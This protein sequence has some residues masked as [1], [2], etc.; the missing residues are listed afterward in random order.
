[1]ANKRVR[2]TVE[3]AVNEEVLKETGVSFDGVVNG[4]QFNE[5]DAIDGFEITTNI[6][7]CDCTSNFFLIGGEVVSVEKVDDKLL[8]KNI[9]DFVE[10][11]TEVYSFKGSKDLLVLQID[12]GALKEGVPGGYS[13]YRISF[14]KITEDLRDLKSDKTVDEKIANAVV[15]KF[16]FPPDKTTGMV[17][18][19]DVVEK[20]GDEI[21]AFL[22][23]YDY[24][25]F[26]NAVLHG[27]NVVGGRSSLEETLATAEERSEKTRKPNTNLKGNIEYE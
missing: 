26:C 15:E 8:D 6:P 10:W 7:G 17:Y 9:I 19:K 23:G 4:I 22:C 21:T 18:L 13:G 3:F 20:T 2:M 12:E 25:C 24:E 1:M 11:S 5:H 27:L 16:Y 14:D